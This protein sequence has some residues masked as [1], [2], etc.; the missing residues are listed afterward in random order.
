MK[1]SIQRA[2]GPSF[3]RSVPQPFEYCIPPSVCFLTTS[4]HQAELVLAGILWIISILTL[5]GTKGK[6]PIK[7]PLTYELLA[8]YIQL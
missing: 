8:R 3:P 7:W 5:K 6:A 1:C 2:G 4:A